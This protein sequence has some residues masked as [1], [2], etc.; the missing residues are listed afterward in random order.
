MR[1]EGREREGE[2]DYYGGS[3]N[4]ECQ[5]KRKKGDRTTIQQGL[6]VKDKEE[7]REQAS[8]QASRWMLKGTEERGEDQRCQVCG[9]VDNLDRREKGVVVGGVGV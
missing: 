3:V 9:V 1:E 4:C 7:E 6:A 5:K 2:E 8:K